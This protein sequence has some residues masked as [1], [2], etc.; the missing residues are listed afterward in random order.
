MSTATDTIEELRLEL[1]LAEKRE[2][3]ATATVSD[4]AQKLR[5]LRAALNNDFESSLEEIFEK[6]AIALDERKRYL[7]GLRWFASLRRQVYVTEDEKAL[8][9][10]VEQEAAK[11]LQ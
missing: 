8:A 5:R 9:G 4:V 6:A 10:V 3:E 7:N 2:K 1:A 11:L